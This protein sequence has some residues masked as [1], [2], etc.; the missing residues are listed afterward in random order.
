MNSIPELTERTNSLVLS[1]VGIRRAIGVSGLLLPVML[2][3]VG[4]LFFGVEIQVICI[5]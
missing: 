5:R 3:P 2:G 1:Y 4:W